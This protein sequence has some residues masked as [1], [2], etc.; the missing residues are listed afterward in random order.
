[1][2]QFLTLCL[3]G[4]DGLRWAL[5]LMAGG[6]CSEKYLDI[7]IHKNTDVHMTLVL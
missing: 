6:K 3:F 5:S 7:R 2:A 1:M 4:L